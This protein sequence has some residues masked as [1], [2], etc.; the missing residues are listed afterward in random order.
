MLD[1]LGF[2]AT[3]RNSS[4][5]SSI[6]EKYADLLREAKIHAFTPNAMQ[7]SPNPP[8]PNFELGEFVFDTLVL[9]SKPINV[10]SV[11]DFLLTICF[12]LETFFGQR[13]PLRGAITTGD[14]CVENDPHLV[15]SDQFKR[16]ADIGGQQEWAGCII[17]PE[18]QSI[19]IENIFGSSEPLLEMQS[20]VAH[21]YTP[22]WKDSNSFQPPI[23]ELFCL[24]WSYMMS[25]SKIEAGL[26]FMKDDPKKFKNTNEYLE[27]LRSLSDDRQLLP[28]EFSP[29][30]TLKLMKTRAGCRM[31]FQ[32]KFGEPANPG[33]DYTFSL[34]EQ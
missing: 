15:I 11:K 3:L 33:C 14:V 29:A 5:L 34:F 16:L 32:D 26:D 13:F 28:T 10:H 21:K 12:L 30:A 20:S 27:W 8:P 17:L 18:A 7:G 6:V 4:D 2:D 1:V 9:V 25:C 19:I 31:F 24:N 23:G 22:P